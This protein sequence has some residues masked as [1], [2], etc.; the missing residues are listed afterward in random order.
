MGIET[1]TNLKSLK[2]M[3]SV[4]SSDCLEVVGEK[5]ARVEDDGHIPNCG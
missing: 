5:E 3:K 4:A 1:W 2:K